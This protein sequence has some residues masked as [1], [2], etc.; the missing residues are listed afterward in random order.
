M[1]TR[2]L[3]RTVLSMFNDGDKELIV[4]VKDGDNIE[5]SFGVSIANIFG[6]KYLL[7][8]I[9][10]GGFL[11]TIEWEDN[12]NYDS[13]DDIMVDTVEEFLDRCLNDW[14]GSRFYE[15]IRCLQE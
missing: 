2:T 6:G 5:L 4:T 13:D 14:Y 12:Y 9:F 11:R 3:A 8:G 10:G 15:I 7:M 1:K